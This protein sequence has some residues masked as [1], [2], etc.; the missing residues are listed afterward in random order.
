VFPR[1]REVLRED[2]DRRGGNG[3][4]TSHGDCQ[5]Q[6]TR[7]R[8]VEPEHATVG[9]PTADVN[10]PPPRAVRPRPGKDAYCSHVWASRRRRDLNARPWCC[11]CA[12][13]IMGLNEVSRTT[14]QKRGVGSVLQSIGMSRARGA[15]ELLVVDARACWI[16]SGGLVRRVVQAAIVTVW[17]DW[18]YRGAC[19]LSAS[20]CR[21]ALP[22]HA[23]A[24]TYVGQLLS[25]SACCGAA[26]EA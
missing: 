17:C 19:L 24:D 10:I 4:S 13:K 21:P 7:L 1:K 12:M 20:T 22:V 15:G 23:A 16:A 5:R 9:P 3:G 2:G 18:R 14:A 25:C 26:V 11:R 6:T 8:P